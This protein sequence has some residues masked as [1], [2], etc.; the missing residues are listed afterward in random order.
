MFEEFPRIK[1]N[2]GKDGEKIYHLPFDQKYDRTIID[3]NKGEF[4]ATTVAEA[5]EH[6]FRRAKKYNFCTQKIKNFPFIFIK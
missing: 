5:V 2:I 3:K 1:C 4:F 6:G